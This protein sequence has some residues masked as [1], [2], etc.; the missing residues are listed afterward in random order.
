M[1]GTLNINVDFIRLFAQIASKCLAAGERALLRPRES[2]REG[3]EERRIE[4][5]ERW[6]QAWTPK[7]YDRLPPLNVLVV[8]N[9]KFTNDIEYEQFLSLVFHFQKF[10]SQHKIH[11]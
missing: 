5:G 3:R 8:N 9:K 4:G 10:T 7:I 2:L 1:A 6:P 11:K